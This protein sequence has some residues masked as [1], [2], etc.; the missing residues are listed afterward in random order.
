MRELDRLGNLVTLFSLTYITYLYNVFPEDDLLRISFF[1][2]LILLFLSILS[3]CTFRSDFFP[4][5]T[6]TE[7]DQLLST[8]TR[9]GRSGVKELR[10][11]YYFPSKVAKFMLITIRLFSTLHLGG[12]DV[13]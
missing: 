10:L 2:V 12:G 5:A 7:D 11:V 13:S 9:V 1:F 8:F 6:P 4:P 3:F